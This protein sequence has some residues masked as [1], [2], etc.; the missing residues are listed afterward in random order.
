MLLRL[1][2]E[3]PKRVYTRSQIEDALYGWGEG[4]SSNAIDVH[5]HHLRKKIT[6]DIIQTIRG[7]G[8]RLGEVT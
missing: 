4:N 2:V 3:N 5:V 1:L 8:Y 6:P 7:I